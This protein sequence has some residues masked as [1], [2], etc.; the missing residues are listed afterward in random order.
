MFG[1]KSNPQAAVS[2]SVNMLGVGSKVEGNLSVEGD[3]RIDGNVLGNVSSLSK[4]AIGENGVI[5]GDINCQ[6]ASIEGR[7]IG[8]LIIKEVLFLNKTAK[9]D[10]DIFAKKLIVEE[11]AVFNGVCNMGMTSASKTNNESNIERQAAGA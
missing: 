1:A 2:K 3:I 4:V 11:G 6:N 8:K 5:K 10:G 9:I 7:V